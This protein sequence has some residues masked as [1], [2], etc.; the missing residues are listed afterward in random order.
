MLLGIGQLALQRA[1]PFDGRHIRF[2]AQGLSF[3]LELHN[4][5]FH[6]IDHLRHRIDLDA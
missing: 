1:P 4:T 5:P 3:N 6:F 2:F